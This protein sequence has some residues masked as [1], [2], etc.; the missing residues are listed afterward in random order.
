MREIGRVVLDTNAVIAYRQGIPKICRIINE[1]D[2]LYLPVIVLGE[3]LY[4]AFNSSRIASNEQ[5]LLKFTEYTDIIHIDEAIT[6]RYAR[7]RL[8]L[9]KSGHPIPEN[10]IWIAASCLELD[11]PIVSRDSHFKFIDNLRIISWES[12]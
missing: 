12:E 1:S 11:A 10:D 2:I 7:I 3:L 6:R 4:G 8:L 5:A 9:K